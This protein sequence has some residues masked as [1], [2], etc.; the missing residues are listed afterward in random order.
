MAKKN[1]T[2]LVIIAIVAIIYLI[3]QSG[4]IQPQV[5]Y[6]RSLNYDSCPAAIQ[7]VDYTGDGDP[8]VQTRDYNYVITG[9]I[10]IRCTEIEGVTDCELAG[11]RKDFWR[12]NA[13]IRVQVDLETIKVVKPSNGEEVYVR[14][15][16]YILW[17]G[18]G[19]SLARDDCANVVTFRE[20]LP[21]YQITTEQR[22][23]KIGDFESAELEPG[24]SY[25]T[26]F[27]ISVADL[28]PGE[29]AILKFRVVGGTENQTVSK[30]FE[31]LFQKEG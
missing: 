23:E 2:F 8:I 13:D 12:D 22:N 5:L 29:N 26:K 3:T 25:T 1:M 15:Y 31:Y 6:E 30:D 24:I 20:N 14:P 10:G 18:P 17:H 19:V 7:R 16:F 4:I 11:F 21:Q 27:N 28:E 9:A